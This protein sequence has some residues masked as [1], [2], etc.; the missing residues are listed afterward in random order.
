MACTW[1]D[2]I[3]A[4]LPAQLGLFVFVNV[5]HYFKK[6]SPW[7]L[8]DVVMEYYTLTSRT[9]RFTMRAEQYVNN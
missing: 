6:T 7:H 8:H 5:Y 3:W 9:T 2:H 1:V 4:F